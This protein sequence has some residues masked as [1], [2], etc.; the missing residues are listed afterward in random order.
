MP[1]LG[2]WVGDRL[3]ACDSENDELGVSTALGVALD[4]K[5]V[6]GVTVR[7]VEVGWDAVAM[8]VDDAVGALLPV[9][10]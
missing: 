7:A 3:G 1:P 2:A 5:D 6:V 4:V 9:D 10:V 8:P